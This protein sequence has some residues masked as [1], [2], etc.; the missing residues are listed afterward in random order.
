MSNPALIDFRAGLDQLQ[1][2]HRTSIMWHPGHVNWAC[3][4]GAESRGVGMRTE[5]QASSAAERHLRFELDRI[6]QSQIADRTAERQRAVDAKTREAGA[7][8]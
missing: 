2:E 3:S 6:F 4:C 7:S 5:R 8:G 1:M